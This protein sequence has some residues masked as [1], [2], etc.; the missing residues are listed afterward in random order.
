M[1]HAAW[2]AWRAATSLLTFRWARMWAK[3]V[4]Y[5]YGPSELTV[6]DRITSGTWPPDGYRWRKDRF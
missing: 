6:S 4:W 1:K 2:C 3:S 5:F